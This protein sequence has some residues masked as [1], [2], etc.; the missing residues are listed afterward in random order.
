MV[1]HF[2]PGLMAMI[3]PGVDLVFANEAEAKGMAKTSDL[4]S[5]IAY[6]K[7]IGREF[8]LTLGPRGALLYDGQ[9]LIEIAPV[10][11]QAL[12]TVGAGDM[13]AGACLFALTQG[14][15]HRNAGHLAAAAAAR[16]VSSYGPRL[17]APETQ[18]ILKDFS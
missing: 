15:D 10:A 3:G 16:L 4:H 5:A 6:L 14:W 9:E 1:T 11:T 7:T 12:D 18:A 13:F 17:P 8:A 2:K